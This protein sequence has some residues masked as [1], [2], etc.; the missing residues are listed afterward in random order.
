ML[1]N[2]YENRFVFYIKQYDSTKELADFSQDIVSIIKPLLSSER[3]GAGIGI[4]E[5]NENT[6]LDVDQILKDLLIAS[7]KALSLYDGDIGYWFFDSSLE[8]QINVKR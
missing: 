4:V 2:T 1:F 5:I 3:I 7:E 8:E 6:S